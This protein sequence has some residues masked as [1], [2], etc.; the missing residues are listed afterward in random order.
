VYK[1]RY[2]ENPVILGLQGFMVDEFN[3]L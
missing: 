1:Y 3:Q 2:K